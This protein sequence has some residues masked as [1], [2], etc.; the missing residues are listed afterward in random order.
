MP[1]C[2]YTKAAFEDAIKTCK[3]IREILLKLGVVAEGGNYKSFYRAAKRWNIDVSKFSHGSHNRYNWTEEQVR[4][5]IK[6]SKSVCATL[7]VLNAPNNGTTNSRIKKIIKQYS[8]DISHFTGQGWSAGKK[9]GYKFPIESYL[10]KHDEPKMSSHE[11]KNRLIG[12][13]IMEHKCSRCG[14]TEWNGLKTPIELDHIDGNH[15]NNLL[16]NLR[17]LCPNCHAQTDTYRGRK[18]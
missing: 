15:N 12:E 5:A 17:L 4:N 10:I 13:K 3:N 14:I 2:K 7:S 8:I 1:Q 11:L 9:F 16:E 18:K 6:I